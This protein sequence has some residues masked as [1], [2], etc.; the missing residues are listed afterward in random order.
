MG[1]L[2]W[3]KTLR[4]VREHRKRASPGSSDKIKRINDGCSCPTIARAINLIV[5]E[6]WA[7]KS[8]VAVES[9]ALLASFLVRLQSIADSPAYAGALLALVSGRR[10][11]T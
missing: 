9:P 4:I 10:K 11:V 6:S 2:C 3:L 8:V 7:E 5:N 1:S